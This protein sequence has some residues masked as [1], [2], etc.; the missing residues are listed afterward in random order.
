MQLK[1]DLTLLI[2]VFLIAV[3]ALA[4]I[5][6]WPANQ[7]VAPTTGGNGQATTSPSGDA[8]QK[9]GINDLITVDG[10]LIN[11]SVSSPLAIFGQARGTWY[12]EASFPVE[13]QDASGKTIAQA[14]AKALSDWM[15]SDFVQFS[16]SLPYPAQMPGSKGT[17]ILKKDNP[18]GDP[19]RDQ[20][21]SIPVTFK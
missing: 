6:V 17:L 1:R 16:L 8:A 13:L 11:A 5:I 20:S 21:V 14:P 7:A 9:A 12:F 3:I 18:S 15:T 10:P 4:V 2:G 19:A